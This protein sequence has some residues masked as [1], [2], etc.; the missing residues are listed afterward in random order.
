MPDRTRDDSPKAPRSARTGSP[1]AVI[2]IGGAEDLDPERQHSILTEFIR[3]SG[4]KRS[5]IAVIPTASEDAATSGSGY[6]R[7]FETLGA[8]QA[9]YL[10]ID[11]REDANQGSAI[12]FLRTATGVFITGGDQARLVSLLVGTVVM[13]TL[14]ERNRQGVVVAGT[15]AG[16]SILAA[17]MM[18]PS[19]LPGVASNNGSP[20]RGETD[21]VS[22]FGLLQDVIIDQHFSQR[23][24]IGRLLEAFASNPGLLGLG[25]DENTATVID[26]DGWLTVLGTGSV[27]I[28]EGRNATSDFF[29][30]APGEVVSVVDS[31]LFVLGPGRQFDLNSRRPA[32][33]QS[34]E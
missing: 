24:R 28:I 20:R 29:E 1:G 25:L 31:H 5:R 27:T 15:S 13:E 3:L 21:L 22:G 10:R 16:A 18:V 11:E 32:P 19:A 4:G 34:D 8:R 33:F 26:R 23:G 6:C 2:P 12:E 17:H 7:H 9:E 30:R 14:R